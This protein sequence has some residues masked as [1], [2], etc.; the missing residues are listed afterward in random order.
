VLPDGYPGTVAGETFALS[1]GAF[2]AELNTQLISGFYELAKSRRATEADSAVAKI[3]GSGQNV[4]LAFTDGSI[5]YRLAA[6]APQRPSAQLGRLPRVENDSDGGLPPFLEPAQMPQVTSPKAGYLV[7]ANQRVVEDSDSR[8]AAIG[9]TGAA[10][11]RAKR[12]HERI[13]ELLSRSTRP[14]VDELLAIQQDTRSA[15]APAMAQKLHALCPPSEG[16]FCEALKEFDGNFSTDSLSALAYNS[17][18]DALAQE[19]VRSLGV[20]D[21]KSVNRW[22]WSLPV[23]NA[24]GVALSSAAGD[25][26]IPPALANK[27]M[28]LA[29]KKLVA[30]TG[31]TRSQW[32]WGR[33]HTLTPEGPLA[34]VPLLGGFFRGDTLEEGGDGSAVRAEGPAPVAHG[35]CLRMIV[36]MSSPPQAWLTLDTGQ[37]GT[38]NEPHWMDQRAA[39]RS[40]HIPRFPTS[41]TDV[42]RVAQSRMTLTLHHDSP[43]TQK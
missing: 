22:S 13:L 19:V 23:R 25:K 10:P 12:I 32:R 8:V 14:K 3:R 9:Q 41:R 31:S 27:A 34:S 40:G 4:L 18:M 5:A 37:G 2:S 35:A 21:E 11:S 7:A 39:W 24:I 29:H 17:A 6:F 36:E 42:E 16:D 1:W 30:T 20:S 43:E 38:P 15:E 28:V 33:F 26:L